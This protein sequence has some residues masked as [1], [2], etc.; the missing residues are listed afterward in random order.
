MT[1]I[2]TAKG[3]LDK[4]NKRPTLAALGADAFERQARFGDGER[5]REAKGP[6][7]RV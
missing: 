3:T 4:L 1:C 2:G 6:T 7:R 5:A